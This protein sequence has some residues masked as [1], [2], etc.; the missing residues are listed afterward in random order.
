VTRRVPLCSV[1]GCPHPSDPDWHR[2]F[3]C[4]KPEGD[5][6]HFPKKSLAGKG[7]KIVAF[8]CRHHH[9][10]ITLNRWREGVYTHPDGS[11][12]YYVQNEKGEEQCER[13]IEPAPAHP[14]P[15]EGGGG[16]W[17]DKLTMSGDAQAP[18]TA[19]PEPVEG[20]NLPAIKEETKPQA[21]P[22][23][24]LTSTSLIIKEK[25]TLETHA[26]LLHN[27]L[28]MKSGIQWWVGD[29]LNK[30]QE[31][32]GEEYAQPIGEDDLRDGKILNWQWVASR[33]QPTTRVVAPSW[34]H[35]RVV[36]A[37]EKAEQRIWLERATDEALTVNALRI[38]IKGEPEA[39]PCPGRAEGP[40]EWQRVCKWCGRVKEK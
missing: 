1:P 7:A 15:V 20:E 31:D 28:R 5:H 37:L 39:E 10:L 38:A 25:L 9:E 14:E 3:V 18:Q 33:V 23:Y 32:L 24:E 36:A 30:A 27:L 17:F 29:E 21:L 34:S 12:R 11:V 19:H 26:Q 16:S 22:S 13:I 6:Q 4:G 40:C 35:A 8:L 2:C